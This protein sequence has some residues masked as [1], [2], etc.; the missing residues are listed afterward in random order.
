MDEDIFNQIDNLGDLLDVSARVK[1]EPDVLVCEC[2][3]VNV[4][5]IR[6]ACSD[7]ATVDLLLLQ[8]KLSLGMG[9]RECLK[10]CDSWVDRIF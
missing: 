6:E 4:N 7:N 9:C 2:F 8:T 5:D 3:C 1:L 10:R